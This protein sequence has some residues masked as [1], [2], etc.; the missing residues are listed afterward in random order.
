MKVSEIYI[1]PIKSLGGIAVPKATLTTRGLAHDRRFMLTTPKGKFMTQ[2][3]NRQMALLKTQI[4]GDQLIVWNSSQPNS[5]IEFPL[6]PQHF[7]KQQEVNI[8]RDTCIGNVLH[9]G[10]NK[11][12]SKQLKQPCQ[13]IYMPTESKRSIDIEYNKGAEIVSFADAYPILLLGQA[14]M[15]DLNDR[16]P[17]P[18]SINRFRANIIYTGGQPFGEDNWKAF[19]IGKQSFRGVKP[20]VR[21]NVPNINQETATIDIHKEPNKTLA[22]FRRFNNKIYVGM[23]VCWEGKRRGTIKVGDKIGMEN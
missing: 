1:Y 18:V 20:C 23:N 13:L 6:Q 21:C 14:G 3:Q 15:D 7:I 17:N 10:I 11:W 2:R 8:W 9:Q 16:L 5:K 19:R 4:I 22:T 12:F